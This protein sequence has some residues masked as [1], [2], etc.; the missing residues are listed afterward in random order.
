M[1]LC[2]AKSR[3]YCIYVPR[4]L[5]IDVSMCFHNPTLN[6]IIPIKLFRGENNK[7]KGKVYDLQ[8]RRLY[9]QRVPFFINLY[10]YPLIP[11]YKFTHKRIRLPK[12]DKVYG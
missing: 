10:Y 9:F 6:N 3:Y 1:Y 12:D 11:L 4:N 2:S 8:R 7:S 5:D